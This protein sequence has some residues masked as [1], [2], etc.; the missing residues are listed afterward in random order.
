MKKNILLFGLVALLL[1]FSC[2]NDQSV[3][4]E[5]RYVE[6]AARGAYLPQSGAKSVD[7]SEYEEVTLENG[8]TIE[9][10]KINLNSYEEFL[11]KYEFPLYTKQAETFSNYLYDLSFDENGLPFHETN[12]ENYARYLE[13]MDR[14]GDE[15]EVIFSNYGHIGYA[16][17]LGHFVE[18][19]AY[20]NVLFTNIKDENNKVYFVFEDDNLNPILDCDE[21]YYIA[22]E[23]YDFYTSQSTQNINGEWI[24]FWNNTIFKNQIIK[25]QYGFVIKSETFE[26]DKNFYNNVLGHPYPQM[27][28]YQFRVI[29][30]NQGT[31]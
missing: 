10:L 24:Q 18:T 8:E 26:V 21:R 4:L 30:G 9:V 6:P 14:L 17:S 25:Y 27:K 31:E 13:I 23:P 2:K 7:A 16:W 3:H 11:K 15:E 28:V 22:L 20:K 5:K 1:M 19:G 12:W 29:M